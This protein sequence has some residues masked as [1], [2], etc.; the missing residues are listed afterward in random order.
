MANDDKSRPLAVIVGERLKMFRES[1]GLR[2][3]DISQ[4]AAA[5]GLLWSRSSVAALEAGT[6]NLSVEELLLLPFVVSNAGGWDQPL[7]PA[8]AKVRITRR[9]H[10]A[11]ELVL[12]HIRM[13]MVPMPAMEG[14]RAFD[15]DDYDESIRWN[16]PGPGSYE[17]DLNEQREM[18]E[19]A[20]WRVVFAQLYPDL[21]FHQIIDA[22]KPE[23]ELVTKIADRLNLPNDHPV[24]WY[25]AAL[26]GWVLWGK[27]PGSERDAR[28]GRPED[29]ETKRSLQSARGHVT[30]ELIQELQERLNRDHGTIANELD[31]LFALD[32]VGQLRDL[33]NDLLFKYADIQAA[34]GRRPE[35]QVPSA[36]LRLEQKIATKEPEKVPSIGL[37]IRSARTSAGLSL[38]DVSS[39]TD[40]GVRTLAEIEGDDFSRFDDD[41]MASAYIMEVANAVGLDSMKLHDQYMAEHSRTPSRSGALPAKSDSQRRTSRRRPRGD[42]L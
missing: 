7:L 22:A 11:G 28:A 21:E 8:N 36:P 16:A 14:T 34:R 20:A 40:I 31:P 30:R 38:S 9:T 2:Q 13:L 29:Y 4:A 6:R 23:Y 18:A 27:T 33:G 37:Q 25:V 5:A 1:K 35:Q 17:N 32:T 3:A 10:L 39:S 15:P 12:E 26:Y 42:K 19:I 24:K 41:V